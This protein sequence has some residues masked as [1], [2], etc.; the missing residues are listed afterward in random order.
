MKITLKVWRQKNSNSK[1]HFETYNLN[2]INPDMSFLEMLDVLNEQLISEDKIPVE[3]DSDCREGICGQCGL[4]INGR[5]N[6][7][8]H[9]STTC[10][11]HMRHFSDGDNIVVEPFR[12]KAFKVLKDLK[13]DR[14]GLDRI[15]QAGG[16]IS[17]HTGSA[18]DANALP[19]G[20][21]DAEEAFNSAACIGCGTCVA[22]CKNSSAALF[23]SAK[24]S[25]LVTL[26]QGK[27]ERNER[28]IGMVNAMDL[29]GF[30]SCTNTEA[31]EMECPQ[32]ISVVNIARMNFEFNR[33]LLLNG[34]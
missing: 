12:A 19:I 6:G 27:I 4:T 32:E 18:P 25:H 1:G 15:V 8:F 22:T 5:A 29:E 16:F 26:P 9:H 3:F 21:I 30:G 34:F 17:T 28:V 31:C 10:Q 14:S 33:S 7:H 13:V 23:T 2:D 20:K 11:M 24:I